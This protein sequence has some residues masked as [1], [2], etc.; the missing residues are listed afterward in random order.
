VGIGS[1]GKCRSDRSLVPF[2][3]IRLDFIISCW[4]LHMASAC[5]SHASEETNRHYF[6]FFVGWS[7][8]CVGSTVVVCRGRLDRSLRWV[9]IAFGS[10]VVIQRVVLVV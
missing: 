7:D 9:P 5:G 6:S 4:T 10:F 3:V 2:L 8:R 1:G